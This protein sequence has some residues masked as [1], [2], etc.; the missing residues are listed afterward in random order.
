MVGWVVGRAVLWHSPFPRA[1]ASARPS[2]ARRPPRYI[3][4]NLARQQLLVLP[5]GLARPAPLPIASATPQSSGRPPI[6]HTAQPLPEERGSVV[7]TARAPI[8]FR[9]DDPWDGRQASLNTDRKSR[10]WSADGWLLLRGGR[11]AGGIGGSGFVPGY[12]GSQAGAVLRYDLAPASPS[13]PQAYVRLSRALG[14]SGES[15]AALGLSLRPLVHI[16]VRL[17]GEARVQR[18]GGPT[19]VRPAALAVTE[20]PPARLPLGIVAE[21]YGAVGY[22]GPA[23]GKRHGATPFFDAQ[24]GAT[25]LL[26]GQ[27]EATGVHAG[28]GLW[29][30]GQKGAARLD[31]GPRLDL[32]VA[33]GAVRG[34]LALDWRFR[35]AGHAA[36]A[37]GPALTFSAGF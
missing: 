32:R 29:S 23:L 26:A 14:M 16:P 15:E 10:R 27:D 24:L 7:A 34:R 36:P 25:R 35:I 30:G 22:S 20:L 19:R 6:L 2:E 31:V 3:P 1:S 5:S 17:L 21:G 18:G 33:T 13:L 4:P 8:A 12:G 9:T 28:A 11:Q 37:S